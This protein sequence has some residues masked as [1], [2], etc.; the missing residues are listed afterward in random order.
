MQK[1]KIAPVQSIASGGSRRERVERKEDA[2]VAAAHQM[3]LKNGFT[4]TTMAEIARKSGVAD[5][6][7]YLYFKNKE[8]LA[9][10]VLADFYDRLT[11]KA[12]AGVDALDTASQRL[13]FLAQHHLENVMAERRIL[14]MLPLIDLNIDNYQGSELFDL[15]KS[16]V[17]VFD[18]VVKDGISAGDIRPD[19]TPW[20]IRDVFFGGLD[21]GVRTMM[22]KNRPENKTVFIDDVMQLFLVPAN[23]GHDSKQDQMNKL[24]ER[25]ETAAERIETSI[26]KLNT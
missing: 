4:G 1:A 14:E 13:R 25:L 16:Y 20:V 10:A 18:R 8:V 11:A 9:R 21:Y 24:T 22:V 5:G 3:F 2:I 17:R 7:V 6:T 19:L 23:S 12:Q 26:E 15:N